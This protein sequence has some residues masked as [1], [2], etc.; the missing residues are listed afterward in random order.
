MKSSFV[1]FYDFSRLLIFEESIFIRVIFCVIN[2]WNLLLF[3]VVKCSICGN[4][5]H[6]EKAVNKRF[7]LLFRLFTAF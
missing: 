4:V 7:V 6:K 1:T 5:L 3:L 2:K